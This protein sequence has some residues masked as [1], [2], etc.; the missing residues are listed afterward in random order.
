MG[1]DCLQLTKLR[2]NGYLPFTTFK[3]QLNLIETALLNLKRKAV[4]YKYN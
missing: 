3:I 1:K 2:D 4:L